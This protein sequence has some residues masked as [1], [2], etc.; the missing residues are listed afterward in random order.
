MGKSFNMLHSVSHGCPL[1]SYLYII[2]AEALHYQIV[3]RSWQIQG[4]TLLDDVAMVLD[5]TYVD[6]KTA[7]VKGDENNLGRLENAINEFC[8][9]LDAKINWNK[10]V[11]IW[12]SNKPVLN[13]A[14]GPI[15]DG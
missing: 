10:S 14:P 8:R 2:A 6:D 15:S 9:G 1:A 13:W 4:L 3:D 7:Y 11:G 5:T 12:I